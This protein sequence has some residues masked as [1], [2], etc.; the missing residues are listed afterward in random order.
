[1]PHKMDI[2]KFVGVVIV[3]ATMFIFPYSKHRYTTNPNNSRN[4]FIN[5]I[6]ISLVVGAYN[7]YDRYGS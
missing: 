2:L 4:F 7:L 6:V 3:V 5:L 1:M